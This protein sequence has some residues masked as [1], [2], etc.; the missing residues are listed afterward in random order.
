[1]GGRPPAPG[2]ASRPRAGA[3]GAGRRQPSVL[4][5][6][7]SRAYKAG[8]SRDGRGLRRS[9]GRS[10]A[11]QTLETTLGLRNLGSAVEIPP[12][13][14]PK[15]PRHFTL[16]GK[17]WKI[18]CLG[19]L[20]CQVPE[21]VPPCPACLP[22]GGPSPR[23]WFVTTN[24]CASK[25]SILGWYQKTAK[26]QAKLK[27]KDDI[28]GQF[29]PPAGQ[30]LR[31]MAAGSVITGW[32]VMGEDHY[33]WYL[34]LLLQSLTQRFDWSLEHG[35]FS[36]L[37]AA[38]RTFSTV[39]VKSIVWGHK[40]Q[41]WERPVD[42]L[43]SD[44]GHFR[45]DIDMTP[46]WWPTWRWWP[47][48]TGQVTVGFRWILRGPRGLIWGLWNKIHIKIPKP[49]DLRAWGSGPGTA[50][51]LARGGDCQPGDYSSELVHAS[52][53]IR[54]QLRESSRLSRALLKVLTRLLHSGS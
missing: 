23:R 32:T 54:W 4:P 13:W 34:D 18:R 51:L 45:G 31:A 46:G 49:Q 36:S 26:Q 19:P 12:G 42:L 40:A 5:P 11:V 8:P 39:P 1:R 44:C 29:S 22:A 35:C 15:P 52:D 6:R 43:G 17:P 14:I 28:A 20:H 10:R 9:H 3:R 53:M 37:G 50:S 2:F 25:A 16:R 47:W 48:D 21:E 33:R 7:G 24:H 27:T 41:A 38:P 30:H